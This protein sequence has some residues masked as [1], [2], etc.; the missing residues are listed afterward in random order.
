MSSKTSMADVV[1][2]RGKTPS[3]PSA[4]PKRKQAPSSMSALAPAAPSPP[5]KSRWTKL[6]VLL[7]LLCTVIGGTVIMEYAT[8]QGL[9][10]TTDST[11]YLSVARNLLRGQG[12]VQSPGTP[13]T[14]FP[15]LY[16]AAL[17]LSG[18][19]RGDLLAG[20]RCLQ[21]LLYVANALLVGLLVYR[22]TNGSLL[23]TIA[24]LLFVFTSRPFLYCHA[25]ALSEPLFLFLTL[26]GLL[27]LHQ[28]LKTDSYIL[29]VIAAIFVVLACLTRYIGI[30]LIPTLLLCICLL[31]TSNWRHRIY[32]IFILCTLFLVPTLVW[33]IRN[34]MVSGNIANRSISFHPITINQITE[35][36]NTFSLWF[37]LPT[38]FPFVGKIF[39]L[40]IVS[41][42]AIILLVK[43]IKI[44]G[45]HSDINRIS[46]ICLFFSVAYIGG[47]VL[48]IFFVE[49]RIP[50]SSRL[51]FPFHAVLGIGLISTCVNAY[52][53]PG[54]WKRLA[55][56]AIMLCAIQLA[57]HG[58]M[59]MQPL[60]GLNKTSLGFNSKLWISS[61]ALAFVKTLPDDALIYSNGPEAIEFLAEKQAAMIPDKHRSALEIKG[62]MKRL[63]EANGYLA[64]F[65]LVTWRRYLPTVVELKQH[66]ELRAVYEGRDGAVYQVLNINK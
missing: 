42:V 15:P 41:S 20:A 17:A 64:Y 25:N 21:I 31:S 30:V 13:L 26:G 57:L 35:C 53:L 40:L 37:N 65:N 22:G 51:L 34:V 45:I 6:T 28:Y 1:R 56:V 50:F 44:F 48:T 54:N 8:R 49:A 23:A 52:H 43:T 29:L 27:L 11:V 3:P 14:H 12:F 18:I 63:Q 47:L 32:A 5:T 24:G 61:Q 19:L 9:A 36:I 59:I 62:M 10:I 7:V 38:A 55:L 4:K 66:A 2:R 46:L 16:P 39:I 58:Q 60:Q 33:I